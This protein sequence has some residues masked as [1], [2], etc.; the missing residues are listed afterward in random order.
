MAATWSAAEG[1]GFPKIPRGVFSK[2]FV[3]WV[4]PPTPYSLPLLTP[5]LRSMKTNV[6]SGH[7][8]KVAD[9]ILLIIKFLNLFK[10]K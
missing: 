4:K 10:I 5:G 7:A 3:Q 2:F 9:N 8:K 1:M 6:N